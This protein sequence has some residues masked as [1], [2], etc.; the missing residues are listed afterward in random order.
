M[1]LFMQKSKLLKLIVIAS[2]AFVFSVVAKANDAGEANGAFQFQLPLGIPFDIWSYY[3]PKN[4][5]LTQAK[6]KLGKELFFDKRLS[7]DGTIS[8]AT[9]HDPALAF[10][11]GKRVSDGIN[12]KRGKRNSPSIL[13]A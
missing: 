2:F 12:G 6:V 5:P 13:N 3:V 1:N 10:T 7:A 4:N 8:C 9:C 11:D